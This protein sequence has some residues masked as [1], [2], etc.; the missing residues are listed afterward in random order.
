LTFQVT[1]LALKN[2]PADNGEGLN[3]LVKA[4]IKEVESQD[5]LCALSALEILCDATSDHVENAK[6]F[7]QMGLV[8]KIYEMM[9]TLK[10]E[11]EGGF[12][13]PGRLFLFIKIKF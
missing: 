3:L 11:P 7:Q 5:I 13:Y 4:I 1:S 10:S 2:K 6:L 9:Q 8:R 12:L